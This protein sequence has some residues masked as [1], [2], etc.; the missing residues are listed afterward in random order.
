MS[1]ILWKSLVVSPAV[2]G[3]TLLVSATAIAAP[4]KTTVVSPAAQAGVTEVTQQPEILAQTTI[5]QVNRYSNEGNQNNSQ[6]QVTSVSQFSDVQP[7]DWAF[8]ALQS[9]VERYGCIAGYPNATYRGNRA[10]TRYEFAAGLNACLDRVNELIATATADLVTKQDLATL[11][12]LQEEFSAELAT[13]RGRVDSL[14]ARTAELEANQFSTTT[15][16]V[17][18]AIF[19]VSDAFGGN[20]GDANNTV[21]Q[22]RVRL[23]LQTS[24]TGR[25]ILHT[26]LAAGNA[27][28]F[29]LVG[30]GGVGINGGVGNSAEGT[31]TFQVG[32]GTGNNSVSIDRL[33]YEAPI[34]PAQVYLA[35][36]GGRHSHYAAVNNP[37]FFDQTDGGNGALSAFASESPIYRI[38]GG[39][40]IALN[41]PLGQG[42]GILGNSSIT[43][44]YLASE[45]NNPALSS[46]LTNGDYAALGQLN[47]S[48]GDRVALA[49]TYVHA[50]N[51]AGGNLFDSG[52]AS[53]VNTNTALGA[54][55]FAVGTEQS[56]TLRNAGSSNSYG[57]SAAFRPSN[58]LSVSGFVSYHD[59]TGGGIDDDYEAWSYGAGVALADFGK[60]GNVLGFFAGAQPYSFNRLGVAAGN[61]VPYQFEGFYKYRV[62]DNI[63]V[64]PGVI[65]LTSPGQNSA[66]DDA[67][68]GTLRTTFSF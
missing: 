26:R 60:Q 25:D 8:Q 43:A 1:N 66:N 67:I 24:F 68:I 10:L 64:T 5:D 39:A 55:S 36:S 52:T 57:V 40:G 44:G 65:W 20:T 21:F 33:T 23:D 41:L 34:G 58:K 62:S 35:A 9:L 6:S 42:G 14:E 3:A 12:R 46:G 27:Q 31:Q 16:L 18:E 4:N 50:Y 56:N 11:Q 13:L 45:A 47:F 54:R 59:V 38:G 7:T 37:Y 48:V 29:S 49:A 53:N 63:S 28:A 51:G 30:N 22:N 19:A 15:K 2:L 32:A 61:D 17:G